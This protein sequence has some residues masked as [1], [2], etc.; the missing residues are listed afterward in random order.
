[1]YKECK[2][3]FIF[4]VILGFF[5][6]FVSTEVPIIVYYYYH[7]CVKLCDAGA[8]P[9]HATLYLNTRAMLN[10]ANDDHD[11]ADH[12]DRDDRRRSAMDQ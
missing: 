4:I 12:D 11:R 6:F 2:T 10:E 5:F 7:I 3:D 1:M 9:A 8:R